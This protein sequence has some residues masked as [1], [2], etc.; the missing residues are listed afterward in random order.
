MYNFVINSLICRIF[1]LRFI[2]H[3]ILV[4]NLS[5]AKKWNRLTEIK[6]KLRRQM[7]Y[8]YR[9]GIV[10]NHFDTYVVLRN[11][12]QVFLMLSGTFHS[13]PFCPTVLIVKQNRVG[14]LRFFQKQIAVG[15][16]RVTPR[17]DPS[18]IYLLYSFN[19]TVFKSSQLL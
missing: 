10:A 1:S 5:D 6:C 4:N 8:L 9:L 11:N 19:F 13:T 7:F 3:D 17:S 2:N 18:H 14:F 12:E 16:H 15:C